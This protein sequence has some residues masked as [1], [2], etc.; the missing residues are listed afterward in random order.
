M[1]CFCPRSQ[2]LVRADNTC[3]DCFDQPVNNKGASCFDV[4]V[5]ALCWHVSHA[6][7]WALCSCS[8]CTLAGLARRRGHNHRHQHTPR[9][10]AVHRIST[11][12]CRIYN[13]FRP[14]GAAAVP[15][16][17]QCRWFSGCVPVGPCNWPFCRTG[18]VF[19]RDP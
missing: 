1:Q 17:C 8:A 9:L 5:I 19:G 4:I 10:H 15:V 3:S 6:S 7:F 18:Y 13:S 2:T 12:S 14:A 11:V 16:P